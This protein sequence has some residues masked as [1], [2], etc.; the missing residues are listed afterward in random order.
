MKAKSKPFSP[1][2]SKPESKKSDETEPRDDR[3]VKVFCRFRPCNETEL[4]NGGNRMIV[5]N[6]NVVN[7]PQE[8]KDN[9]Y[10]YD[11]V[12]E[13]KATQEQVYQAVGKPL[14]DEILQGYNATI[15]A[16]GQSGCLSPETLILLIDGSIIQARDVQVGDKLVDEKG[17]VR[18]VIK[19][20]TGISHMF[21]IRDV[22]KKS[23]YTVN[24][25]HVLTVQFESKLIDMSVKELLKQKNKQDYLG[26]RMIGK[27]DKK[28]GSTPK[29][30]EPAPKGLETYPF[31]IEDVGMGLY[32]GFQLASIKDRP[33]RFLLA[34]GTITH[35]S[36][37]TTT[38]TGY[39]ASVDNPDALSQEGELWKTETEM[40]V[41]PRLI[42]DL[43]TA[44]R[45]KKGY[46]FLVSM[47]YVEIYLERIRDLLSPLRDD[48][49]IREDRFRGLWIEDVTE[50][51][52]NCFEDAVR[53]MRK[54]ELNRTVA[55]TAMNAHSSRSHSVLVMH[56]QQNELKTGKKIISRIVFVDLAGSEKVAKTKAE[57]LLLKQASSTN[58]SLLTL[59]LVIR[60]LAEKKSFIPYRD[61][62]LTRLLTDSLGGNS[63]THLVITCSPAKFNYEETLST[64][65]FGAITQTILNKPVVNLEMNVEEYKR[66]LFEANEKL[67]TQQIIISALTKDL[68]KLIEL[69]EKKGIDVK[70]FKKE[71]N[72]IVQPTLTPA[73][74]EESLDQFQKMA[75]ELDSKTAL[76][77]EL[78]KSIS[79]VKN[80]IENIR[81]VADRS[82]DD[83]RHCQDDLNQKIIEIESLRANQTNYLDKIAQLEGQ[84]GK[85]D[86]LLKEKDETAEQ[87]IKFANVRT[88]TLEE[89]NIGLRGKVANLCDENNTLRENMSKTWK[90][91]EEDTK[92]KEELLQLHEKYAKLSIV[93]EEL[94]SQLEGKKQ[95][96]KTLE[97]G[98][99]NNQLKL[100]ETTSDFKRRQLDYEKK[101]KDLESQ[102]RIL[103]MAAIKDPVI[104]IPIQNEF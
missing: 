87:A 95:H 79:L 104:L 3:N 24:L 99:K 48:L 18:E 80:E 61:S 66:L 81:S 23:F 42:K 8:V 49:K 97:D 91:T 82:R 47:S 25:D 21:K 5:V 92:T 12:F 84:L 74:Y 13:E 43:F 76:V 88:Q 52:V 34:D 46:E 22:K 50:T 102:L 19:L 10:Y 53:V 33:E 16:Y 45:G 20:F 2:E 101:I 51:Y 40:G 27:E 37:K 94:K 65:R 56:L 14:L 54:G 60:S 39:A 71:Y 44:I 41:V 78:Q 64:L 30:L 17:N 77:T 15:F 90:P 58:K 83:L 36:G 7:L 55:E 72:L 62:K 67:A 57:G 38:M 89:E 70:D 6:G 100:Q 63:K 69:C 96:V 9:R 32:S 98:L 26:V 68:N 29:G 73:N 28:I 103:K 85:V 93:E 59:G 75:E 31:E 86:L 11:K 4:K 35:N 1:R